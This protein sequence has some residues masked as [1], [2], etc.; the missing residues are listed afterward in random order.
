MKFKLFFILGLFLNLYS[1]TNLMGQPVFNVKDY[2]ARGNG[3]TDDTRAIQNAINGA[4]KVNSAIV[5]FPKATYLVS[6]YTTTP[7][8]QE[9]Y[10]L[11]MKSGIHFKGDGSSSVIRLGSNLF[12]KSVLSANAHLFYGL[13]VSN[14]SFSDLVIDMNGSKNIV[15]KNFNKNYTSI[16]AKNGSDILVDHVTI[17]NSAGRTMM[18]I[19]GKGRN[20][21][22]KNSQFLNGGTYPGNNKTNPFQDDF[23]FLYS[24]WDS[25][26]ITDN[27]IKQENINIALS[28]Y[29]GGMEL[30][31]NNSVAENNEITGCWPAIYISSTNGV[32]Q[33]NVT[34][35][36]NKMQ[37]CVTGISFWLIDT[38]R[39][40]RISG[41]TIGLSAPTSEKYRQVM[42]WGIV[43]P[44]GNVQDYNRKLA[45][46]APIEE[47][48]IDSNRI[49]A[50]SM[51]NVCGG[52]SL[53][54]IVN[55]SILGN[56]FSGLNF[57]GIVLSGSKWGID[58]LNIRNNKFFAFRRNNHP[59][60]VG[61]YFVVTDTYSPTKK[62]A[63]A[64][65]KVTISDNRIDDSTSSLPGGKGRILSG[66]IALPKSMMDKINIEN[67]LLN[68]SFT[69]FRKVITH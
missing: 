52:M 60:V 13:N 53:H 54:S 46:A 23:S 63:R 27:L 48:L 58:N 39:N 42:V 47:L 69:N 64:F 35:S 38:M 8:Y 49:T 50:D 45:N 67:N 32:Q 2:G 26:L 3:K 55:A 18:N 14:I 28:G 10:M 17:R 16:F 62:N 6:S 66:F 56:S 36:N 20:L 4:A 30:H 44:N 24:E 41:N 59:T 5:Y 9:N 31:G 29:C 11:L 65:N 7:N 51:A 34:V 68:N 22:I 37:K 25:T 40:I 15:P 1:G 43:M 57:A 61:G 19:M 12:D 33:S 21:V